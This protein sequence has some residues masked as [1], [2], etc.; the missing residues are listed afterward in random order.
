[1]V[2]TV[3]RVPAQQT[4]YGR[5]LGVRQPHHHGKGAVLRKNIAD[6]LLP[7]SMGNTPAVSVSIGERGLLLSAMA[8]AEPIVQLRE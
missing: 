3:L 1:M 2:N 4:V 5:K 6:E 8:P 7:D